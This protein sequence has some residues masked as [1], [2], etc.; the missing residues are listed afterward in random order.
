MSSVREEAMEGAEA[1]EERAGAGS[2]GV[3]ALSRASQRAALALE[4]K[5][6]LETAAA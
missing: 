2:M 3:N 5:P 4:K 1:E 6:V